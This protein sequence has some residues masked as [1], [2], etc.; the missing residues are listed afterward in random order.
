LSNAVE[1]DLLK[2]G[3][4]MIYANLLKPETIKLLWTP[5]KTNDNKEIEYGLGWQV[6]K[7]KIG[8]QTSYIISHGNNPIVTIK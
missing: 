1:K 7:T 2:F 5:Q 4:S 3:N 6:K 8:K